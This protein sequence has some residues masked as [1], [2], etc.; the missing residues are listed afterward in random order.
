MNLL[1]KRHGPG[2]KGRG[3]LR[4]GSDNGSHTTRPIR[5]DENP[6]PQC[7]DGEQTAVGAQ[8][9]VGARYDDGGG[10][11]QAAHG[12]GRAFR[13]RKSFDRDNCLKSRRPAS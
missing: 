11:L 4:S 3:P 10:Y 7:D 1:E 6:R 8:A 13:L 12:I 9:G 5:L 2:D